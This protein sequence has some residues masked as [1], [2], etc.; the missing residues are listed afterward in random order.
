MADIS[1]CRLENGKSKKM[2]YYK[3][4]IYFLPGLPSTKK[5][6]TQKKK[7]EYKFFFTNFNRLVSIVNNVGHTR[8]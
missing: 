4:I 3:K 8:F 1:N 7:T 6:N 5:K 2:Y